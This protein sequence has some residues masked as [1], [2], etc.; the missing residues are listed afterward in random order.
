MSY[1]TLGPKPAYLAAILLAATLPLTAC[2]PGS[3]AVNSF[4]AQDQFSYTY[5]VVG[6]TSLSL[7]A[8]NGTIR[9]TGSVDATTVTVQGT[10]L[11]WSSSQA[12]AEA[13]LDDLDVV[14][15]EGPD[16]FH[17][18]TDQPEDDGRAYAVEYEIR[19]PEDFEM[20]MVSGNGDIIVEFL[21]RATTV[22]S[23]NADINLDEVE[24]NVSLQLVNGDVDAEVTLPL[25][26]VVDMAV[27]SGN[28]TLEVPVAT[29]AEFHFAIGCCGWNFDNLTPQNVNVSPPG[30]YPQTVDGMLGDGHGTIT[31]AVGNGIISLVGN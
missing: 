26:A 17:V 6:Q 31:L 14:V 22:S 10:R 16:E 20:S 30:V 27:T 15:D 18:Y 2:D 4:M 9:I 1:A 23:V 24:G 3:T 12:D 11:V 13:G 7:E 19:M 21:K 25:D 28:I 29:S 5:D 8:I